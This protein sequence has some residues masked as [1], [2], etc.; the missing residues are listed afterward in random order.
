MKSIVV[1][2]SK[3]NVATSLMAI[4]ANTQVDIEVDGTL[5]TVTTTEPIPFGHKLAIRPLTAGADVLKYGQIVGRASVDI[6]P[7][8]WVHVHNVESARGRGDIT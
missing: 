4:E 2:N 7:G 5:H 8:Q 6:A 1:L 3:D